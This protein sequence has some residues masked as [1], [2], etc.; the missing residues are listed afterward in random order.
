MGCATYMGGDVCVCGVYVK[1]GVCVRAS[2]CVYVCLCTNQRPSWCFL[3]S[4]PTLF[5]LRQMSYSNC[6]S[7]I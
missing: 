4:L 1:G 2:V 7:L 6:I 3:Q 5:L